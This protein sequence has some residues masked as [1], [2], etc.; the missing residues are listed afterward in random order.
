MGLFSK[1]AEEAGRWLD[2]EQPASS[3]DEA[4]LTS[5]QP[6]SDEVEKLLSVTTAA[7]ESVVAA[8]DEAAGRIRSEAK[9]RNS[10]SQG[11]SPIDRRQLVGELAESLAD[12]AAALSRDAHELAGVLERAKRGLGSDD[13]GSP[14]D[15][16]PAEETKSEPTEQLRA[17][18]P[19]PPHLPQ[20]AAPAAPRAS[21]NFK[22]ADEIRRVT[23]ST[24][25][26][27]VKRRAREARNGPEPFDTN[28]IR[29]LATQMAV[30]GSSGSE[31]E[32]RLRD[33]FGVVDPVPIINDVL[34]NL[35][36][37][38]SG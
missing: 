28:G 25:P 38:A 27:A 35:R 7:V 4:P 21:P 32:D 29:L 6:S 8:A 9:A 14:G 22:R 18:A 16:P 1:R 26:F 37:E 34:E 30:A 15:D 13:D 36:S 2:D 20:T 24:R 12:R 33:E 11:A 17:L 10:T 3:A 19:P 23:P 31:I 5:P